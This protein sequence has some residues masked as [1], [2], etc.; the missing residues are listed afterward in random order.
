MLLSFNKKEK[1][2]IENLQSF[3]DISKYLN[4]KNREL[5]IDTVTPTIANN[6]D[7][8]IR[9]WNIEDEELGKLFPEREPIKIYINSLGGSLDAAI[10]IMDS[11]CMSRTPVYTFNIGTVQKESFLI[12]L[13]GHKRLAYSNATFMY[14][15]SI[16]NQNLESET[17]KDYGFYSKENIIDTLAKNIRLFFLDR[18]GITEAQYNKHYKKDWWF[19]ADDALKIHICNEIS[20]RHF[21]Y[22]QNKD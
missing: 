17:Q 13:A 1:K 3:E 10:T 5:K 15:D 12:Y 11:I 8:F 21:H 9:F 6:I 4:L 16:L 7:T 19:N 20:R 22:I 14:T 2:N 18:V